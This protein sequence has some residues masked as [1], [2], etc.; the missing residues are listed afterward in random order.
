MGT[1]IGWSLQVVHGITFVRGTVIRVHEDR[2]R[3]PHATEIR[4]R[5]LARYG[6]GEL[7]KG[8]EVFAC[9]DHAAT[10]FYRLG[11][12]ADE[13]YPHLAERSAEDSASVFLA[14]FGDAA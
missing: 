9:G 4:Q 1:I 12:P 3:P 11:S 6:R 7:G 2:D 5:L 13:P 8:H 10:H 14:L